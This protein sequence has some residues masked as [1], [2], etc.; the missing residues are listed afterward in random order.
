MSKKTVEAVNTV[1]GK[2][3]VLDGNFEVTDGIRVDGILK[4][5]LTSS[6]ALVVGIAGE[7][8]AQPIRV[9]D[10]IVAGRVRGSIEASHLV[11]LEASAEMIGD[12]TAQ[13]LI[14]EEGAVLHG[15]CDTGSEPNIVVPETHK[16]VEVGQA[17]G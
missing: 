7:V 10:A 4:G 12:I 11:K 17:V 6:G 8:D 3:S 16:P 1:V 9:K 13:V 15:I 2:G 5:S 14:I